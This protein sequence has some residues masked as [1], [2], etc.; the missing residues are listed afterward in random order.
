MNEADRTEVSASYSTVSV[1]FAALLRWLLRM[2]VVVRRVGGR[3]KPV[4]PVAA[5][6]ARLGRREPCCRCVASA[7]VWHLI[8]FARIVLHERHDG[9]GE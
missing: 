4:T 5:P 6:V 9:C 7:V 8:H 1:F 3:S 2:P